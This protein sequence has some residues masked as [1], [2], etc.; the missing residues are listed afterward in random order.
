MLNHGSFGACPKVVLEA[1]QRYRLQ[2]EQEPVRFFTREREP[3]LDAARDALAKFL[4]ADP[5]DLVFVRNATE[6]VNS[7]LRSLD[8]EPD[9]ELLVTDHAYN[10]CRNVVEYV[11]HRNNARVVVA[12]IC[13]PIASPDEVVEAVLSAVTNKN[14]SPAHRSHHQPDGPGAAHRRN[15]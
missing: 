14:A 3:L 5:A 12:K 4:G 7:V 2:M 6:G 13:V 8:F 9:D 1:Q 15:H 10:A 11:A